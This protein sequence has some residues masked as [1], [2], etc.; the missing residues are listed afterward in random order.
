MDQRT[1][2]RYKN[3][4]SQ[5]GV[6]KSLDEL[7]DVFYSPKIAEGRSPRTLEMYKESYRYLCD[8]LTSYLIDQ[9]PHKF[10]EFLHL[11][12]RDDYVYILV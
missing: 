12:I 6:D 3:G 10:D 1:G 5:I 7:F 4:R 11:D 9:Q 8:F 2:K